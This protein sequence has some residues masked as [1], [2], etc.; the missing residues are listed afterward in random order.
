LGS[1]GIYQDGWWAGSF[2]HLPWPTDRSTFNSQPDPKPWELYHLDDDY[3]QA[4]NVAAQYPDK[5]KELVALFDSEAKRNHVYPL[6]PLRNDV[7]LITNGKTSFLYRYGQDPIMP[8]SA[9][10]VSQRAHVITADLNIPAGGATGAIVV[11]GGRNGGFTLYA[12]SGT[13]IY[14][15]NVNSHRVGQVVASEPLPA[16][17]ITVAVEFTPDPGAPEQLAV[18]FAPARLVG[19]VITLSI[20]GKTVGSGHI[21]GIGNNTD[22]FD[23]GYDR[24]SPVSTSYASPFAF[25]GE[26]ESIKVELK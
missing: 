26:V 11:E 6:E 23:I 24:G 19:G 17:K 22:T 7:P 18:P 14:E 15:S 2:N 4:H 9:P 25:T 16:G 8:A 3:S 10:R 12:K 21:P 20:N 13:L 5:L 1:R